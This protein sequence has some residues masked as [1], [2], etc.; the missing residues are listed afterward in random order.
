MF[1]DNSLTQLSSIEMYGI[2]VSGYIL[3]DPGLGLLN[4]VTPSN[5]AER[6]SGTTPLKAF[7]ILVNNSNNTV[8]S[9]FVGP[10]INTKASFLS[11][12]RT[13]DIDSTSSGVIP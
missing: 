12:L 7:L 11:I 3:D 4:T 6:V 9:N 2:S 10:P 8:F 5:L 1:L 13:A